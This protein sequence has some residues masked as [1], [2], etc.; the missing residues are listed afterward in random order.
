MGIRRARITDIRRIKQLIDNHMQEGFMLPRPLNELFEHVREFFVYEEDG[1]VYGCVG[2]H[3]FWSNLAEI[4]ALVVDREHG[5]NRGWGKALIDAC[6]EEAREL[7]ISQVFAL[8]Q[9]PDFFIKQGFEILDKTQFPH[10]VWTEC[11]RCPKFQNCDEVAVGI[12]V[13]EPVED[14]GEFVAPDG[15]ALPVVHRL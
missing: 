10:K 8:T 4:K 15:M 11:I 7:Q 9:I 12:T 1:V 14:P 2:L 5:R 13:C 3:I 6:L